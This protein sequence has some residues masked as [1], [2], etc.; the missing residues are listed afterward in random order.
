MYYTA[1]TELAFPP[2]DR[3]VIPVVNA[4]NGIITAGSAVAISCSADIVP[5]I[6]SG[7]PAVSDEEM[8][9]VAVENI[10]PGTVGNVVINGIAK[11]FILGGGGNHAVPSGNGLT[12]ADSGK[13]RILY[14][15]TPETPG[16]VI[17]GYASGTASKYSGMFAIN[18]IA[19]RIFEVHWEKKNIAGRTDLPG[20]EEVQKT[21]INVP[22]NIS[23][24]TVQL[25]GC[26]NDDRY[27]A[28]I[29][30]ASLGYPQG[31]FDSVELGYI[32]AV[33]GEVIQYYTLDYR[34]EFGRR[35]FL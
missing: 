18:C 12:A 13:A 25:H 7:V 1:S 31:C 30:L 21:I 33:S 28:I 26:C 11:A 20:A 32:N 27:S 4:G 16:I 14:P 23:A 15:G 17:L 19:P 5:L 3:N 22:E 34:I 2:V 24:D 10:I 35:W 9:G 29:Q 8:W 6:F